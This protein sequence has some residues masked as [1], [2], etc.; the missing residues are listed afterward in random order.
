MRKCIFYILF[1][2]VVSESVTAAE[3][4]SQVLEH[5]RSLT[6]YEA[7]HYVGDYRA[8]YP[9]EAAPYGYLG[10]IYFKLLP[11]LHPLRD[12]S[13]LSNCVYN[14]KLYYGNCLH[15][16]AHSSQ[17]A[18]SFPYIH[19]QSNTLD[20]KTINS[21]IRKKQKEVERIDSL[22]KKLYNSFYSLSNRYNDCVSLYTTFTETHNRE[23]NAHLL[24]DDKA[25]LLLASLQTKA[26]SLVSD[27][28]LFQNA[29]KAYPIEGYKPT[30]RF[31][32]IQLY[33]I[34]GLTGA[35][36]LQNEIVLWDYKKWVEAFL[37]DQRTVYVPLYADIAAAIRNP[38]NDPV[39]LN[40]IERYAPASCFTPIVA[41]YQIAAG[42]Q[43][44]SQDSILAREYVSETE[45]FRVTELLQQTEQYRLRW[46]EAQ[47]QVSTRLTDQELR[48]Y[49][50]TMDLLGWKDKNEITQLLQ[51]IKDSYSDAYRTIQE[52]TQRLK[53]QLLATSQP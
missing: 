38:M 14:T 49:Q 46:L 11:T 47:Q 1:A 24:L 52:Q 35:N 43:A 5:C 48:K 51:Q 42:T 53:N 16:A 29:L 15:Y 22:T 40:R 19:S 20:S 50:T 27:I 39:I 45:F 33:R 36:F 44:L 6:P 3:N 32:D 9:T 7:I 30:I 21:Y 2:I 23:K 25:Q 17:R 13:E 4:W 18:A 41:I 28:E 31:Q 8:G 10:E 12:Y 37:K 26:D 34:D